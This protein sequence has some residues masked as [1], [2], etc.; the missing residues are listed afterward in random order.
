MSTCRSDVRRLRSR[1][2]PH[3]LPAQEL[4]TASAT[5]GDELALQVSR[6]FFER[7]LSKVDI[8][9]RLGIS[10]FRVARLIDQAL[11]D[12]VVRIEFRDAAVEDRA[13]ARRLEET[14]DLDLAVVADAPSD[15]LARTAALAASLIDGL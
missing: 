5:V 7:Q 14:F 2:A 4:M 9:A 6:L 10:R 11:D 1:G 3:L 8:A 12:G 15:A 13:L